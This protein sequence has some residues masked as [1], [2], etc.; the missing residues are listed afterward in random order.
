MLNFDERTGSRTDVDYPPTPVPHWYRDAKVGIMI[1]W[2]IYSIPAWAVTSDERFSAE[3]EYAFHRYAEWYG[4]TVR[5]PGSPTAL[6]HRARY[7]QR[8][9]EDLLDLWTINDD[10]VSDM[11]DLA[12][13]AGAQYVV[14]TT[15]HHD[16]L[17]LWDTQTTQ[18]ST[19][20]RGPHRDLIA[21]FAQATRCAGLR[22]G[23][24]FS[25]A[26]DWHVSDFGPIT[27]DEELFQFRRND[28]EFAQYA[29]AQIRELINQYSPD[30]LWNDIDWPD[31]GKG[32]E[33]YGLAQL[34]TYYLSH[35]PHGLINDRWGVPAQGVLT[36]EY[37][38]VDAMMERPWEAVRGLG[39]S[40]GYNADED[41]SLS[42][43][44]PDLVRYLVDVVAKNGNLLINI[45]PRADGTIPEVQRNSL[46][47]MGRWLKIY[48]EAIYDTRP[49]G[50]GVIEGR[51]YTQPASANGS[52]DVV[53]LLHETGQ[54]IVLPEQLRNH[55]ITRLGDPSENWPITVA[56]L[57]K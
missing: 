51:Y 17:C 19:V 9:Y 8:S 1:H 56:K 29:T 34:F 27:S 6:L 16:G 5:I 15:K 41:V 44:G 45:G 49:W 33:P 12:V 50:P 21:E 53:Y 40:F 31:G 20:H 42:L 36:R 38:D 4:N 30:Y 11:I 3:E 2:G 13:A 48:G 24:Y 52:N 14:P 32:E 43:S 23:L 18:F 28:A 10:A 22:L 55:K 39:R 7:G 35:V 37:R 54:D 57:E 25:G 46:E 47:Y 26:L